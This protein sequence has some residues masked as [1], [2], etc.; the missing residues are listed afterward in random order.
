MTEYVIGTVIGSTSNQRPYAFYDRDG[1]EIAGIEWFENDLAA[2]QWF[3]SAFPTAYRAGV[4][5]RCW[6]IGGGK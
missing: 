4:E 6:D 3:R 5:M 2:E 1:H